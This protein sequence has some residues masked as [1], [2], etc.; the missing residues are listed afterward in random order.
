M[1]GDAQGLPMAGKVTLI[2]MAESRLPLDGRDLLLTPSGGRGVRAI[3]RGLQRVMK[4]A[5]SSDR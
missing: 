3:L 4:D 5:G 2:S 1:G